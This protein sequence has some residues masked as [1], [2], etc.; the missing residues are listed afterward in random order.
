M[1]AK[2]DYDPMEE[3]DIRLIRGDEYNVIDNSREYWWKARN[4]NGEE[5]YIPS[6][7]VEEK[8]KFSSGLEKYEWFTGTWNR[9]RTEEELKAEGKDGCFMVRNSS[10]KGLY[11]LSLL[12]KGSG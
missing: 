2:F 9:H 8:S 11:T 4:K 10:I 6:N 5:G 3:M 7:Y 1:I 12:T